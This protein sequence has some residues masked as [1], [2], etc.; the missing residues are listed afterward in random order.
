M[1]VGGGEGAE[2]HSLPFRIPSSPHKGVPWSTVRN[3]LLD[4]SGS[5]SRV[6]RPAASAAPGSLLE[7]QMLRLLLTRLW[8][9]GL[10][11]DLTSY[12]GDFLGTL[13]SE[14]PALNYQGFLRVSI[15]P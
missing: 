7:M 2:S 3:P 13:K 9:Q 12:P 8:S 5:Q 15:F 6:P 1:D 11:S 14:K 10:E 4:T